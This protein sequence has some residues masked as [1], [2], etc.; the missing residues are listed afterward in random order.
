[1]PRRHKILA[2]PTAL[3]P[4]PVLALVLA[5]TLFGAGLPLMETGPAAAQVWEPGDPPREAY[6]LPGEEPRVPD[7][8]PDTQTQAGETQ[9]SE[10]QAG[11]MPVAE[12]GDREEEKTAQ[13]SGTPLAPKREAEQTTAE[14]EAADRIEASDPEDFLCARAPAGKAATVPPPFD[15]WLVRV[16]SPRGQALVPVLGEAWVA[17]NSADPVS[18]LAMPPGAVPPPTAGAFDARYDIRFDILEGGKAEG[19]RLRRAEALLAAATPAGETPFKPDAIWQLDAVSNV[20]AT[21]YNLFFYLS[22]ER[23]GRIIACLDQ[24]RQALFLDV[25]TGQE[26]KE[27]LGQQSR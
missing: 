26:A 24:C 15:R 23:P 8:P 16:C 7:A 9:A 14:P 4:T 18:I 19:E 2:A 17:H 1:M 13:P 6:G 10:T 11:M 22:G 27:A 21:R 12:P 3:G 20:A 25:L 5:L